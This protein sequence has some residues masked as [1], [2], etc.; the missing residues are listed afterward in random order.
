MDIDPF[1]VDFGD[2][3]ELLTNDYEDCEF[4][5][6]VNLIDFRLEDL[7]KKVE[8]QLLIDDVLGTEFEE[9]VSESVPSAEAFHLMQHAFKEALSISQRQT[10]L[11]ELQHDPQIVHELEVTPEVLPDL[12]ENNPIVAIDVLLKM[13]DSSRDMK[14]HL[15]A[16]IQ[17]DMSVYSMEVV[18]R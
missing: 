16:L 8:T 18:N 14:D 5:S 13:I 4:V 15:T 3:L 2:H 12:V 10:L 9:E 17:M 6:S 7:E 1:L 11:A